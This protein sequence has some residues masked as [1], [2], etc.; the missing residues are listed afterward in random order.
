MTRYRDSF[1]GYPYKV[2]KA[3]YPLLQERVY[4]TLITLTPARLQFELNCQKD[5]EFKFNWK[6]MDNS[7]YYLIGAVLADLLEDP[8]LIITTHD[9]M[10][11]WARFKELI[12]THELLR[13]G[14]VKE[15]IGED[16]SVEYIDTN[17]PQPDPD[18]I[19]QAHVTRRKAT[20]HIKKSPYK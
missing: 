5:E 12:Y 6:T 19:A 17:S 9:L 2:V 20:G 4:Q 7:T 15:Q 14:L 3:K 1:K 16:G 18:I 8:K 10:I 13:Q 11:S